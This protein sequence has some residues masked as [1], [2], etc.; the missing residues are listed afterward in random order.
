MHATSTI[1]R[2]AMRMGIANVL[3]VEE[4][5]NAPDHTMLEQ[6]LAAPNKTIEQLGGHALLLGCPHL[7]LG[8]IIRQ[9]CSSM[10]R[11]AVHV[12]HECPSQPRPDLSDG[13][14]F[15]VVQTIETCATG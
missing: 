5:T 7:R 3:P 14:A 1:G 13:R 10:H 8:S 12:G 6:P 11:G 4:P 9:K 15:V 2:Y